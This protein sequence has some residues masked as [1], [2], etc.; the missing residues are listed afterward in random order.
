MVLKSLISSSVNVCTRE[1]GAKFVCFWHLSGSFFDR[2]KFV[3]DA[4]ESVK[5]FKV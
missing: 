3:G 4:E 2:F 1:L 5:K